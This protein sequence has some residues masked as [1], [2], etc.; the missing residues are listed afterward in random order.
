MILEPKGRLDIV[1]WDHVKDEVAKVNPGFAKVIDKI[2]PDKKHWLVKVAYPYGSFVLKRAVL[3]LPNAEGNIVPIT[4]SS[5]DSKL[6]EGL[7]YNLNSNPVSMVLKNTFELFLPLEDRVIP[8]LGLIH[9]GTPFGAWRILN[10]HKNLQPKFIWDMTAGARSIFMLPKISEEKKHLKLKKIFNL[11]ANTPKSLMMHWEIFKEIANHPSFKQPWEAEILFFSKQWFEHLEDSEW[12]DFYRY[13]HDSVWKGTDYLRNQPFWNLIF[14]IILKEYGAKPSGYIVDTVKFL[15][16]IGVGAQSGFAP[17]RNNS[18]GPISGLQQVYADEYEIRNYPPII[19]NPD[20]FNIYSQET[21]PIYYSLQFP[22]APEFTPHS[23]SRTSYISD[24][25]EIRSLLLRNAQELL[26]DKFNV[27]DTPFHDLFKMAKY[28]YFHNN[29]ELHSG[30]RNS[31]EMSGED[32]NFL[33]TLDGVIHENFP[34]M[35]AFVKGCI[36]ISKK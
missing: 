17:A 35:S 11:S 16:Y 23:R 13:F 20:I 12:A 28:D 31:G 15:M 27:N 6:K 29:V 32:K 24:L 34:D 1:T 33:T 22:T 10:P 36:R 4:D 5:L 25:H 3:M 18:S 9:P 21:N 8:F 7:D 26:S 2:N 30:M 19:I 14:S